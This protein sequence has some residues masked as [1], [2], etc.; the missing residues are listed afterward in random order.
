MAK[1]YNLFIGKLP[2]EREVEEIGFQYWRDIKE[3]V[4]V[5][6][7]CFEIENSGTVYLYFNGSNSALVTDNPSDIFDTF[8]CYKSCKIHHIHEFQNFEDANKFADVLL[9][10]DEE[11]VKVER[12]AD[13][14]VF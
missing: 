11:E 1:G 12:V 6:C 4:S 14:G 10:V 5:V 8:C 3:L 7:S 2:I 9:G 13:L